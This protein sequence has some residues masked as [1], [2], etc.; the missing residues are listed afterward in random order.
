M[1]IKQYKYPKIHGPDRSRSKIDCF[2]QVCNTNYGPDWD[3]GPL[4]R[5][6]C[7]RAERDVISFGDST[8]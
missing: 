7:E 2:S 8:I 6:D 3:S 4:F 1:V 5:L